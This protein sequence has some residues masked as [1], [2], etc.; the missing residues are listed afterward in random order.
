MQSFWLLDNRSV[1]GLTG[2]KLR[3]CKVNTHVYII[4]QFQ[5]VFWVFKESTL[6]IKVQ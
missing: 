6:I 1:I 2:V 4:K 3:P 5:G